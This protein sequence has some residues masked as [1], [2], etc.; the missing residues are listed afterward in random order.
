M[1]YTRLETYRLRR[2]TRKSFDNR[3]HVRTRRVE[4]LTGCDTGPTSVMFIVARCLLR[5]RR[6]YRLELTKDLI[7]EV[8]RLV[9][10]DARSHL[11]P[12]R[13]CQ[14]FMTAK[15]KVK[16]VSKLTHCNHCPT[17]AS[18]QRIMKNHEVEATHNL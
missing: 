2:S 1:S 11:Q 16:D 5:V 6:T 7:H 3:E 8:D 13:V 10:D 18:V 17:S 14:H 4:K 9:L 15:S 12:G